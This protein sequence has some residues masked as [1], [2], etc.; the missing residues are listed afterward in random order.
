MHRRTKIIAAT[1]FG[2][3]AAVAAVVYSTK[4]D[5]PTVEGK[6][7]TA[8]L[9]LIDSGPISAQDDSAY[10]EQHHAFEVVKTVGTNAVP[11]L[12]R[13]L[14]ARDSKAK[15]FIASLVNRQSW[16]PLSITPARVSHQCAYRG[17]QILGTNGSG[18]IPS[19]LEDAGSADEGRRMRASNA[20]DLIA[21]HLA[22]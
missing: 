21:Y 19:L 11:T 5:E 1:L 20:L 12:L 18:A 6:K 7:L 14:R 2:C 15:V 16:L 4:P 3:V 13:L 9:R 8:W 10:A 22:K 17:F